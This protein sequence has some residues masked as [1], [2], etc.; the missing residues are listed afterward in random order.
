MEANNNKQSQQPNVTYEEIGRVHRYFL[1][2]R[3]ALFAGHLAAVYALF[4]A[5]S[6]FIEQASQTQNN[7]RLYQFLLLISGFILTPVFWGLERRTRDLYRA[8]LSAGEAWEN[9]NKVM[10]V[11]QKLNHVNSKWSHSRI[12]DIYFLV[13]LLANTGLIILVFASTP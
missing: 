10:G 5:Y 12:L 6:R 9:N 3:N 1:N 11:Y 7:L 2:W 13:V 8:C 4:L